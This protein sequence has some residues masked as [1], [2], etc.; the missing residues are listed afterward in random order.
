MKRVADVELE[1][2]RP[3][4]SVRPTNVLPQIFS[5]FLVVD[6]WV[7][8]S[9]FL[10][11]DDLLGL[12]VASKK[13]YKIV[14]RTLITA[15][16]IRRPLLWRP[17]QLPWS[18]NF[19]PFCP[20]NIKSVE[21]MYLEDSFDLVALSLLRT[22]PNLQ[23]LK[24]RLF[25]MSEPFSLRRLASPSTLQSL[26]LRVVGRKTGIDFDE[27]SQLKSLTEMEY[28]TNDSFHLDI[29]QI[30]T[31]TKLQVLNLNGRVNPKSLSALE[32]L[33]LSE[34]SIFQGG[35]LQLVTS[36][37]NKLEGLTRLR[38]ASCNIGDSH[39]SFLSHLTR[40]IDLDISENDLTEIPG[41]LE[42]L[43][44]LTKLNIS[45]QTSIRKLPDLKPLEKLV[46]L[47]ELSVWGRRYQ[48]RSEIRYIF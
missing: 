45:S 25:L 42:N 7:E 36:C 26:K 24:I 3:S 37:F 13:A 30:K 6:I 10:G 44:S 8:I 28:S 15:L 5:D 2:L 20:R 27:I 12:S 14:W 1:S 47:K 40:L 11:F 31:L 48:Q 41:Q 32:D 34:L 33:Q 35:N 4:P 22:L 38:V 18:P 29:T 19:G 43:T 21:Y 39:I 46:N 9:H 17:G 16:P 23:H